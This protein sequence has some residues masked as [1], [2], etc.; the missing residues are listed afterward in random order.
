VSDKVI[1]KTRSPILAAGDENIN[2][3][4]VYFPPQRISVKKIRIFVVKKFGLFERSEFTNF[5]QKI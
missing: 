3:R 5:R 4:G 1:I 2:K